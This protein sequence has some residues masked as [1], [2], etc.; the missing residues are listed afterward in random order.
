[1]FRF[2]HLDCQNSAEECGITIFVK[3]NFVMIVC[4]SSSQS[5]FKKE[6]QK[7]AELFQEKGDS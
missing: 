2:S 7:I 4:L 6:M 5:N 3:L 1:M